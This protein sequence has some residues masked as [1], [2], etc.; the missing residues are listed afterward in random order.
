MKL[1]LV[2]HAPVPLDVEANLRASA[3]R[4]E[5]TAQLG[6]QLVV[7]PELWLTGYE[8]E[9]IAATPACWLG[10]E[11]ARLDGVR[12]ACREAGV[13]AILGGP[14]RASEEKPRLAA[15]LVHGDGRLGF[16]SKQYLHGR[17]HDVF[18][19]GAPAPPFEVAG[20]RVAV[21]ICFDMAQPAHAM[22][23]AEQRTDLYVGSA[24]YTTGEERRCDLHFG[25]RAMDH[26]MFAAL[27]NYAGTSGG[28]ISCGG[29]G[30][31]RPSGEVLGRAGGGEREE[32]LVIEL[33]R[34]ELEAFRRAA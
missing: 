22:A 27:A 18:S 17:E 29:S 9:K 19:A 34:G 1:A 14:W 4:I 23:A 25:A 33:D 5:E 30:V 15:I 31:W 8:L 11:D 20:W 10:A 32:L 26:R 12:R 28:L 6:A 2:Q 21:A 16:S 24:L 7:F 13:T 3:Q